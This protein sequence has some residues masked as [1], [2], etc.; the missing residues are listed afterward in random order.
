[1]TLEQAY[2]LVNTKWMEEPGCVIYTVID[3]RNHNGK[4]SVLLGRGA[5][6]HSMTWW[7]PL[8]EFEND[9]YQVEQQW[10]RVHK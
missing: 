6:I 3:V 9:F 2:S 5:N 8:D 7:V 1:M 4:D 10:V